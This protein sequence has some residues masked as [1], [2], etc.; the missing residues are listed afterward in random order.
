[1]NAR[2]AAI[3]LGVALFLLAPG[4]ARAQVIRHV[5]RAGVDVDA[6]VAADMEMIDVVVPDRATVP[7]RLAIAPEGAQRAS[8]LMDVLVAPDADRAARALDQ[9]MATTVVVEV[10]AEPGLGDRAFADDGFAAFTRDNVLVVIRRIDGAVDVR[11]FARRA[12]AAIR[13]APLGATLTTVHVQLPDVGAMRVG[14]TARVTLPAGA[15]EI[16]VTAS[17]GASARRSRDGGYVLT[18]TADGAARIAAVVVD[19]RCRSNL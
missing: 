8:L 3:A 11:A 13:R 16:L 1:M 12:D 9:Q 5:I 10:R 18:R 19:R 15:L 4:I 17:G 14:D 7:L 6:L 2:L